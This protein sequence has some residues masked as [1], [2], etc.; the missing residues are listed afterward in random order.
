MNIKKILTGEPMPDKNDPK[1]KERYESEVKAGKTFAEKT[2]LN[3]TMMRIQ[4]WANNHRV[5][6]LVIVFGIVIGCFAVNIY[7]LVRY[8]N[9]SKIQKRMTAVEQ[10]DA[11]LKQQRESHKN[12]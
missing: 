4:S 2:G 12:Q 11:A 9:A 7:N 8:Y 5:V 3:W 6:F 10:V 1:Y